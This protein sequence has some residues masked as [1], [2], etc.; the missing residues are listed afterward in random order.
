MTVS[1]SDV[2]SASLTALELRIVVGEQGTTSTIELEG[3][4]DL[5]GQEPFRNAIRAVLNRR[6]ECLVLDFSRLGFIDST[7]VQVAVELT[8]RAAGESFRLVLVPGPRAVQHVFEICGLTSLL[9]FIPMRSGEP[10][11]RERP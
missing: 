11:S 7:G 3:E 10:E 2:S 4:C 8:E 9:P 5:N 1:S 6:P